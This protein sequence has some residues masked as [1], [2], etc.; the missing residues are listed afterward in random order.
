MSEKTKRNDRRMSGGR[1]VLLF[2]AAFLFFGCVGAYIIYTYVLPVRESNKLAR[3]AETLHA[4][5]S[6]PPSVGPQPVYDVVLPKYDTL[7][8][9]NADLRGWL[10]VPEYGVDLPVVQGPD[11]DYYLR[12]SFDGA[13]SVAGTPFFDYRISDFVNLPRNTVVYGHNMRRNDIM[14]GVFQNL[15]TVEG[16]RKCPV[17]GLD[18]LYRDYRWFVYAVF[19]TNIDPAQDNGYFFEYNFIDAS[20]EAFSDYVNELDLRKFYTTG[21]DLTPQDK[22]LTIS[23]CCYDFK[24]ARLVV[25]ARMQ[26]E[27]E[28]DTPDTSHAQVNPEPKYP[29]VW[30]SANK[31]TNPY[32]ADFH[33]QPE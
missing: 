12:R 13:W 28:P 1:K 14:F 10:R 30:Y 29:Q 19:I 6:E 27:N 5:Q 9:E 21:V 18:T 8:A 32:A 24:N 26:R 15:R 11:N 33:Y 4:D 7:L 16:Y 22:L 31:L 3:V 23:T 20:D 2:A 17:I 25:V